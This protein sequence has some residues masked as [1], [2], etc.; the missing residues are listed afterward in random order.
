MPA[1]SQV[2]DPQHLHVT[3]HYATPCLGA[4]PEKWLG[5]FCFE[6]ELSKITQLRVPRFIFGIAKRSFL[7]TYVRAYVCA[8]MCALVSLQ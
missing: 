2:F 5:L 7:H 8:D 1:N 6:S 4:T 3:A